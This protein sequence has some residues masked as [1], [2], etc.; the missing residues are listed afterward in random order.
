MTSPAA[1]ERR[2]P[3]WLARALE[4]HFALPLFAVLPLLAIWVATFHFIET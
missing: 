4:T 1:S 2:R 3:R